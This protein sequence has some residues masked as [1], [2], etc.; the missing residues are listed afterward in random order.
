MRGSLSR[1]CELTKVFDT[2]NQDA[3]WWV[4]SKLV[5]PPKFV[6]M[7]AELHRDMKGQVTVF[8]ILN[9]M[10]MWPYIFIMKW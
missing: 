2:L 1:F 3:L 5:C 9:I 6:R 7:I 8:G 10:N 4:L